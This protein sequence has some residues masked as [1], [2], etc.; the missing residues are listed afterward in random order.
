MNQF[1]KAIKP[2]F[3]S[4]IFA[5]NS[6]RSVPAGLLRKPSEAFFP[7]LCYKS[8]GGNKNNSVFVLMVSKLFENITLN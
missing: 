2:T 4:I 7:H 3:F 5:P 6:A 8:E 1:P